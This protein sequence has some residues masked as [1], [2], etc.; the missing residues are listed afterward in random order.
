MVQYFLKVFRNTFHHMERWGSWIGNAIHFQTLAKK[1]NFTLIA[2]RRLKLLRYNRK[3]HFTLY[4]T[5][6]QKYILVD[7]IRP[8]VIKLDEKVLN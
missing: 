4:L 2:F 8:C 7:L 1:Y 6:F 5:I 3:C